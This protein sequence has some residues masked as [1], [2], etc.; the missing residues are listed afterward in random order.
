[1]EYLV[2]HMLCQTCGLDG[3]FPYEKPRHCPSCGSSQ[4]HERQIETPKQ[5]PPFE[6]VVGTLDQQCEIA[7]RNLQIANSFCSLL[8]A[9]RVGTALSKRKKLRD[10]EHPLWPVFDLDCRP[11]SFRDDLVEKVPDYGSIVYTIWDI[12]DTLIYVGIA[13]L[14]REPSQRNTLKKLQ[15]IASGE[16]QKEPLCM[17]IHDHY[18]IPDLV[19]RGHLDSTSLD[20]NEATKDFIGNNLFFRFASFSEEV[21]ATVAR[22]YQK[23]IRRG[24]YGF[25]PPVLNGVL[26]R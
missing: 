5:E 23:E 18:V 15:S 3:E 2:F 22:H 1:M 8:D 13:G 4:F 17:R 12:E 24:A 25:P 6:R 7:E 16:R 14:K 9:G 19:A 11:I 10:G 26:R 21:S 20:L